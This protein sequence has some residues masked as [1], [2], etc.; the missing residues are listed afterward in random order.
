MVKTCPQCNTQNPVE[1]T[2]CGECGTDLSG[3]VASASGE[4]RTLTSDPTPSAGMN[5]NSLGASPAAPPPPPYPGSSPAA[6]SP[7]PYQGSSPAA[8]SPPYGT[9]PPPPPYAA[10]YSPGIPLANPC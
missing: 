3:V 10:P 4:T 1:A 8:P 9:V 6:P 7:P 2:F 5:T